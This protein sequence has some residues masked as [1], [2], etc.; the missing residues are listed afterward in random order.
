VADLA[1]E[2]Q[3]RDPEVTRRLALLLVRNF[4]ELLPNARPIG[5]NGLFK[6]VVK[7]ALWAMVSGAVDVSSILV[8]GIA[9]APPEFVDGALDRMESMSSG[10]FWEVNERVIAF[11][12][13]EEPLRA[14]IP[15]LRAA[16]KRAKDKPVE[17]DKTLAAARAVDTAEPD[18]AKLPAAP[19]LPAPQAA[20]DTNGANPTDG[21][22]TG[23]VATVPATA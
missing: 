16:L 13:V 14:Q 18:L 23:S 11:D 20:A 21:A 4:A 9:S 15:R 6:A 10:L 5:L 12:W 22:G 17:E 8:E 7:L 2:A 1:I 19:A 3:G